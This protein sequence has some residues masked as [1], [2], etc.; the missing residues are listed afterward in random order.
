MTER[1]RD[2][3]STI[4]AAFPNNHL[5]PPSPAAQQFTAPLVGGGSEID[6]FAQG[7]NEVARFH[8]PGQP[9]YHHPGGG[10]EYEFET[11][12]FEGPV[13]APTHRLAGTDP[14]P[15]D[16]I[17]GPRGGVH[18]A[19]LGLRRGGSGGS[20][21]GERQR[22]RE[23]DRL[24]GEDKSEEDGI[25]ELSSTRGFGNGMV[26]EEGW[27]PPQLR[28]AP[29]QER[30]VRVGAGVQRYQ[31]VDEVPREGVQVL[32]A[33]GQLRGSRPRGRSGS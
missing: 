15:L 6:D 33:P 5:T 13:F 9:E 18:A 25:S 4:A 22:Q 24:M 2:T 27:S 1:E 17:P 11:P 8:Q 21:R 16:L 3:P 26:R 28:P 29:P 20:E 31:L 10:P 12:G 23:R 7:F 19:G 30:D 32:Q 14:G